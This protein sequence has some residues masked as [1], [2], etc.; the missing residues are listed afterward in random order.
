M[1]KI[2]AVGTLNDEL[3]SGV[4]KRK[5]KPHHPG[6]AATFKY[7]RG[8]GHTYKKGK[9]QPVVHALR[10]THKGNRSNNRRPR[11][12][13]NFTVEESYDVGHPPATTALDEPAPAYSDAGDEGPGRHP[14]AADKGK[15]ILSQTTIVPESQ[16][17]P[18]LTGVLSA[19]AGTSK[20]SSKKKKGKEN[21][22]P[23]RTHGKKLRCFK[24]KHD[25]DE[26]ERPKLK[27]YYAR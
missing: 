22:M 24:D 11:S 17:R 9:K 5:K 19:G 1:V 27:C 7:L 26:Q 3:K 13:L 15:G 10:Q 12:D 25:T 8:K 6:H 14:T 4:L 16:R 23:K 21:K 2:H 18:V 20:R